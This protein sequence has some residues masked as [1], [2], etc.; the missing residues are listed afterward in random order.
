MGIVSIALEELVIDSGINPRAG[1]INAGHAADIAEFL[2]ARPKKDTPAIVVYR[3]PDTGAH[4]LSEGFHRA[5]G[6]RQAGRT[7]I[8]C[9]VRDGDRTAALLNAVASNKG[10][11]LKRTNDDKRL[12]VRLALVAA[13]DWSNR[14]IAD[15]VGVDDKTVSAIRDAI[16]PTAEIPQLDGESSD[17]G[18]ELP[19]LNSPTK[20]VGKDGK[21]RKVPAKKPKKN[22]P[23]TPQP[24]PVKQDAADTGGEANEGTPPPKSAPKPPALVDGTGRSVPP[25][26]RDTFFDPQLT[27]YI[28]RLEQ[29][30]ATL[31]ELY[32]ELVR[33]LSQKPYPFCHFG[34]AAEKLADVVKPKRGLLTQT[35]DHLR[36]GI[37]HAVCHDC[38]GETC[39]TC[40]HGG[41]LPKWRFEELNG[42][43]TA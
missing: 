33:V 11:G 15:H 38:G 30:H 20:R 8:P 9:E 43:P 14:R 34:D 23:E 39:K 22:K 42:G 3:D 17:S 6:Y 40:R 4:R 21:A 5:E 12:A 10:H 28:G 36:A 41:Y 2:T 27:A 29:A 1:G 16:Y 7:H 26:L 25:G 31:D 32:A 24:E 37:P 19:H 35:I 13:P 18:A